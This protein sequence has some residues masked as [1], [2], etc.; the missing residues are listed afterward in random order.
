MHRSIVLLAASLI[1]AAP[2]PARCDDAVDYVK[3]IRPILKARC[4]SCHGALKQ[5]ASLRLDTE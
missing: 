2:D 1:L 4:Y 3:Q 5:K